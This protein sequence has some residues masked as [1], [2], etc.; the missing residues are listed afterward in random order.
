M[1]FKQSLLTVKVLY[2]LQ[3]SRMKRFNSEIKAQFELF[4]KLLH[5]DKTVL[6]NLIELEQKSSNKVWLS[7]KSAVK[8]NSVN[9]DI[10]L[11]IEKSKRDS[12]Y[13]IKLK[14]SHL[15]KEPFFRFDSD[16]PAHRNESPDIPIDEQSVSTP[17][18]N[19]FRSDGLSIAYQN[20]TLKDESKVLHIIND[21][22]FG[23]S[24]FCMESKMQLE[25][26]NF[27]EI[28]LREPLLPFIPNEKIN[29]DNIPFE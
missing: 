19:S 23:I 12:K 24:L 26:G 5:D 15:S 9:Q 14:C 17:H 2:S 28:Y 13:G 18:F 7:G 20:D 10:S 11:I 4:Q 25:D 16:G 3:Y 21:I 6:R 8:H 29:F 27:P 1:L 22:N